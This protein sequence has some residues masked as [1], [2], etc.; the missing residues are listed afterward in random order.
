MCYTESKSIHGVM[1]MVL[2]QTAQ[3][4][5]LPGTEL[6]SDEPPLESDR[7]LQQ[8]LFL[9]ASLGWWWRDCPDAPDGGRH[10]FFMA[11]NL[12]IYFNPDQLKT[13]D[14]RG[15]DFFVVLDTDDR[16]RKSW[17]VWQENYKCPNI[18]IEL[19]S[20]STASV[21][22]GRKKQIYQDDFKTP[23]YFWFDPYSFEF[24]GF[25]LQ[26]SGRYQAIEKT[27]RGWRWS[28]QLQ[29]YLGVDGKK[30]RFFTVEGEMV[31]APA[32]AAIA[33]RERAS[34]AY[35]QLQQAEAE[36]REAQLRAEQAEAR[37]AIERDRAE[38]ERQRAEQERQRAEKFL[39]QLHSLGVQ[40]EL[41]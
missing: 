41:D 20:D 24:K 27:A 26:P 13:Q 4:P 1:T 8:I 7:H 9:L 23:E 2:S 14:F 19:L 6:W 37:E 17:V 18:I 40:P 30:L 35:L 32:E 11:G 12:T 25:R 15:P 31:P 5:L 16:E 39:E 10:D 38:Q 22:R 29:L 33:E 34:A 3:S 28:E 21:D 36:A